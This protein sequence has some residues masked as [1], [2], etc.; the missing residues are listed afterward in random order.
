M[1]S[2]VKSSMMKISFDVS[3]MVKMSTEEIFRIY[4]SGPSGYAL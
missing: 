1:K 4:F 2:N 3:G